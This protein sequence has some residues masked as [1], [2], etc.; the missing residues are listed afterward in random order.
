MLSDLRFLMRQWQLFRRARQAAY[1]LDPTFFVRAADHCVGKDLSEETLARDAVRMAT[2]TASLPENTSLVELARRQRPRYR[3]M[4]L[5]KQRAEFK[6][7]L[8]DHTCSPECLAQVEPHTRVYFCMFKGDIHWCHPRGCPRMIFL[9]DLAQTCTYTHRQT[10]FL[11]DDFTRNPKADFALQGRL[12]VNGDAPHIRR[13]PT[14]R[15][16]HLRRLSERV[17]EYMQREAPPQMLAARLRRV[18][19]DRNKLWIQ[20]RERWEEMRPAHRPDPED[21]NSIFPFIDNVERSVGTSYMEGAQMN[22]NTL[23]APSQ[24]DSG[25]DL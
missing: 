6:E 18:K 9:E 15:M 16:E 13:I 1:T 5:E 21:E 25:G 4:Q 12:T 7:Q 3:Q 17:T 22:E 10:E 20:V 14:R 19:W 2:T 24:F 23:D 8:R 11:H